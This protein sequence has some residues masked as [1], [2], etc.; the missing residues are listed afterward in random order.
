MLYRSGVGKAMHM[1]Q[2]SWPDTYNAVCDLARHMTSAMQVHM[3]SMLRLM[4]Y[5]D[6][7]RDRGLVL[8]PTRKW[9][10]SKDHEFIISGRSDSDYA[11]DTQTRKSI[12]GYRVLLEAA[13]VMFRSST[14]KSLALLVCE[15]EQSS[16]VLCT[17]VMLYYKVLEP[18]GKKVKLPMLLK[19]DNKGAVDLAN[20]WSV[21]G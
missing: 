1:M 13:P 4:K 21:G 14:Q 15:A 20:N 17:Q 3:D 9:D 7:T 16:G 8:N 11:K 6:N 10:G 18:M 2:Y 12:S 5:I 19:M